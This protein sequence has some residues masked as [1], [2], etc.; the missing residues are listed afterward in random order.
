M[1]SFSLTDD[2]FLLALEG[3]GHLADCDCMDLKKAAEVFDLIAKL[4]ELTKPGKE[5]LR[6]EG[7]WDQ[8]V[9]EDDFEL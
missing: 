5:L 9:V 7:S 8:P 1:S 2:D 6:L 3:L 4:E